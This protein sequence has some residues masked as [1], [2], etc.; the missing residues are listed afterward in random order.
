M[1]KKKKATVRE[2]ADLSARMHCQWAMLPYQIRCI[3]NVYI[4][5]RNSVRR[6]KKGKPCPK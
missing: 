6:P 2:R 1:A 5:G 3:A 4:A